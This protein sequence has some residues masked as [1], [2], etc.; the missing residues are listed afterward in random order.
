MK[1]NEK[2]EEIRT[3]FGPDSLARAFLENLYYIQGRIPSIATRNDLYVALAYTVRDRLL[4]CW[5]KNMQALNS[6]KE[7]L[8]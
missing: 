7:K 2:Y 6:I 4:D 8:I 3:G 1:T 5:I